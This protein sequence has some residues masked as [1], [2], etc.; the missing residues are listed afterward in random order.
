MNPRQ[1]V[2]KASVAPPVPGGDGTAQA[3]QE[4]YDDATRLEGQPLMRSRACRPP[5]LLKGVRRRPPRRRPG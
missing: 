2:R 4:S 5:G 1:A 3:G